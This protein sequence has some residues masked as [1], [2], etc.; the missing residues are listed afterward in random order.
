VGTLDR[1]QYQESEKDAISEQLSIAFDRKIGIV[2]EVNRKIVGRAL[3]HVARP[4]NEGAEPTVKASSAL[5]PVLRIQSGFPLGFP[6]GSEPHDFAAQPTAEVCMVNSR[7]LT[8]VNDEV[9][10]ARVGQT[11]NEDGQ[12]HAGGCTRFRTAA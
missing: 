9:M 3:V 5:F 7:F 10:P 11:G 2:G 4:P 8:E 6:R 12:S 1:Q